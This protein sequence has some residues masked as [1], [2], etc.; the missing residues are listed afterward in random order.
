MTVTR[1]DY[2]S[3]AFDRLSSEPLT[4]TTSVHEAQTHLYATGQA[5]AV[6]IR[7]GR[8]V[9][10]VT[11]AALARAATSSRCDAP[12]TTVM[13]YVAVPVNPHADTYETVRRFTR[14]AS[15][16]LGDR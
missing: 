15:N 16:W 13:D 1:M 5:A 3:T 14:V 12:I 2:D 6:V 10:I 8:P 4:S 11:A 9:G 7:R